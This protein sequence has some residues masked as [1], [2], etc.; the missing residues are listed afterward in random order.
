MPM[1]SRTAPAPPQSVAQGEVLGARL[2][3]GQGA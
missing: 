1:S 2:P 3:C